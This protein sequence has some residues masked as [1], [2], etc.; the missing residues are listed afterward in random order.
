MKAK[1]LSIAMLVVICVPGLGLAQTQSCPGCVLGI[2]DA[3]DLV[4]NYGTFEGFQKKLYVGIKYDPNSTYD[5]A[6]GIELSIQGLPDLAVAPSFAILNN[7]IKVGDLITTPA[8]TTDP[9]AVGGWNVVW[10]E[11][12]AGN[13]VF[14][15]ITLITFDP[16]PNDT[17]IRV[18]RKF[19]PTNPTALSVLFTQCD[20]PFFTVTT[21]TGGCYVLNPTVEPGQAVGDPP[22]TLNGTPV[23][24]T[25]WSGIKQLFR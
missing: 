15:E 18:L 2:Y 23:T 21:M 11:C 4:H 20:T 8:D 7:G 17:V 3:N 16:I 14:I 6:T 19:P 9:S 5:G 13:Q 1:L 10:S 22:C 12:Q 24:A 25:T